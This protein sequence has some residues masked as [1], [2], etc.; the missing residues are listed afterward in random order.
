MNMEAIDKSPILRCI[1][2][3]INFNTIKSACP[4]V[5]AFLYTT[6]APRH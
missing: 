6:E 4:T 1:Y 5:L 2:Y 3:L